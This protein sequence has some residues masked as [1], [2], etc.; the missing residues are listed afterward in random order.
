VFN[1]L[2]GAT[3][4][5]RGDAA[6]RVIQLS[7]LGSL[8]RVNSGIT[9]ILDQNITLRGRADNNV[10]LVDVYDNGAL[11]MGAGAKITG[12]SSSSSESGG[13]VNVLYGG[14][15][16]MN[17]GE[18]SGNTVSSSY[19]GG[20]VN[21]DS[22]GAV[23]IM[24]GGKIFGN[25]SFSSSSFSSGGVFMEGGTFTMSGGEISG[26]TASPSYSSSYGGG[27]CV[28]NGTFTMSGGEIS[29]NTVSSS[30]YNSYGGGVYV[31]NNGTFMM[32]GGKIS[33]NTAS[34]SS[35]SY[36]G[37]VCVNNTGT[38]M[39][40]GGEISGNTASSY[41]NSYGGGVYVG[42][43]GTFTMSNSGRVAQENPVY[44]EINTGSA[45]HIGGSLSGTGPAAFIEIPADPA[46]IGRELIKKSVS[47][48]G[49]LPADRFGFTDSWEMDSNGRLQSRAGS[50]DFG[51]TRS[52]FINRGSVHL[53]R[54]TPAF[55]KS[56]TITHT[57]EDYGYYYSN[58]RASAAWADGSGVLVNRSSN[59]TTPSFVADK[60]GVD[61]IIMVGSEAYAGIYSVNYNERD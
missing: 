32:S 29:G 45:I 47:F 44:L 17:D 25:S 26:N 23:F 9:L 41:Y 18:I 1:G 27:V 14:T 35:S 4:T 10:S 22:S 19:S 36:G 48:A 53:Y 61:I 50:L 7:E 43:N 30:Y 49:T 46:W 57:H 28:W 58:V 24:N 33:G 37:G 12:N 59:S 54:F 38:F 3:L 52:A 39:M 8:F 34:S 40:S 13:G 31:S 55:N 42:D 60:T 11:E 6:E 56:Y 2:T 20:G 51:E 15:F 21:V 5:L 16:T